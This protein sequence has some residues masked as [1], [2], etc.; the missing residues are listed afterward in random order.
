M[1]RQFPR[2]SQIESRH[3]F[4]KFSRKR[5]VLRAYAQRVHTV[6]LDALAGSLETAICCRRPSDLMINQEP[7]MRMFVSCIALS[8]LFPLCGCQTLSGTSWIATEIHSKRADPAGSAE[9][10]A[11]R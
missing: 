6:A 11:L 1:R 5:G 7:V 3:A 2:V 9:I 10:N 8:A 4:A